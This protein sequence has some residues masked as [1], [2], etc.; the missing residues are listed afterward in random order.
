MACSLPTA[1]D[2]F[3][4]LLFHA[5][6]YAPLLLMRTCAYTRA[7]RATIP[8]A[9]ASLMRTVCTPDLSRRYILC[10]PPPP[11]ARARARARLPPFP[12]MRAHFPTR[13]HTAKHAHLACVRACLRTNCSRPPSLRRCGSFGLS[14]VVP[15]CCDHPPSSLRPAYARAYTLTPWRAASL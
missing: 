15:P 12:P 13:T 1:L 10:R 11:H 7:L 8:R 9:G 5:L 6:S 14:F 2:Y 3:K 4:C